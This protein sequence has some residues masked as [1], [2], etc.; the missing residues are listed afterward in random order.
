MDKKIEVGILGATGTVGQRFVQLL[1]NHPWFE[2][3]WVAASD[4]SAGKRYGEATHW[5]QEEP[6]PERV[7]AITVE[8]C[9]P[10]RGPRLVFS[11][12]SGA[13]AGEIEGAFAAA[14]HTVVSNSGH[15]RMHPD[16]PLLVPEINPGHLGLLPVQRRQRGWSG[17]VV[18]NPNCAAVVVVLPFAA[19]RPFGL[20]RAIVTTFQA[21]S[22]AGYPGVPALDILGN[23][24]PYIG[25]DEERKVETELT[26]ILGDF[27]PGAGVVQPL[28]FTLSAACNRVPTVDGHLVV[29]SFELERKVSLAELE[30]ALTGFRGLPQ[31][32]G[33]PTAPRQPIH[34][35]KGHDRPQPR[36][37]SGL[38]RGMGT[39]VGRLRECPV[40]GYKF[41]ALS[42]N[43][44]RGAAGAAVLNAELMRSEGLL[45]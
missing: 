16:V 39:A 21:A 14:G 8:E 22:G 33:L 13:Q 6:L 19:L 36:R 34:V 44:L 25:G 26:K 37:D 38:E 5:Q 15:F 23:V 10:G 20:K 41:V 12:M 30:A 40:L 29:A 4:R 24:I 7:A 28:P 43:V 32:R 27:D 1:E 31:E 17:A 42:H 35:L 9:V 2:L 45:S 11:S 18:T 3:T